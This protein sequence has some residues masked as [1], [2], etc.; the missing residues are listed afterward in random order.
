MLSKNERL[1][2][3]TGIAMIVAVGSL[4]VWA[5]AGRTTATSS[6]TPVVGVTTAFKTPWGEPD[7]QGIW[8]RE[9]DIPLERPAKYASQEV[10]T[11]AERA[12]LD[13]QIADIVGRESNESRRARGTER[14]VNTEFS[15]APYTVHL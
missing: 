6:Q 1:L 12:D 2:L 9:F 3:L 10:F 13:R 8:S 15:Q 7:L 14:D 5:V 4:V 11:D